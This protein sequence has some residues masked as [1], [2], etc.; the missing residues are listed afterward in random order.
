MGESCLLGD[1][2]EA[3]L[4]GPLLLVLA[5]GCDETVE[6]RGAIAV[7]GNLDESRLRKVI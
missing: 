2:V 1:C 4:G 3:T 5:C 7:T 6:T